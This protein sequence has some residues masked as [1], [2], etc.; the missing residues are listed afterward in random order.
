MEKVN[1]SN[2]GRKPA[3][4]SKNINANGHI[5]SQYK[6]M[7]KRLYIATQILNGILACPNDF[8]DA[9]RNTIT[10]LKDFVKISYIYADE[11]LEQE[12]K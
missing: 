4:P 11:L 7:S 3:F 2:L 8:L 9:N 12:D 1:K 5:N 10:N 6:G